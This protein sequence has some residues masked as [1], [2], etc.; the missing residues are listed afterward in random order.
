MPD[1][2]DAEVAGVPGNLADFVS[3]PSAPGFTL[4]ARP[5]RVQAAGICPLPGPPDQPVPSVMLL[6][7]SRDAEADAVLDLLHRAGVPTS[8]IDADALAGLDVLI[9]MATQTVRLNDRL[10][11]PTVT[12]I[13]H[14]ESRAIIGPGIPG[15]DMFLTDSWQATACQVAAVSA[16]CLDTESPGLISQLLLARRHQ[17]EVPQTVVTTDP[18]SAAAAFHCPRLVIKAAHRHFVEPTPGWLN[19]IFP[20]VVERRALAAT[21]RPGPWP[22]VVVQEYVDHDVEVRVYWIRGQ[23]HAFE[24]HKSTPADPWVAMHRVVVRRMEQPPPAVVHATRLLATAMT[25]PYGAFDFLVRCGAPV[26]LEA[27]LDG[28]WRWIE[29]R[30]GTAP[31]SLSVARMLCDLHRDAVSVMPGAGRRTFSLLAFLAPRTPGLVVVA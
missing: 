2:S 19:W 18:G 5:W 27:N 16:A 6:T 4:D 28:D 3:Q 15:D 22:P 30:L 24:V 17:I 26:F 1:A 7:R 11:A 13:R 23:M 31:V 10:L 12:W 20:A 9:D 8:R 14:F 21:A 29:R 25:V